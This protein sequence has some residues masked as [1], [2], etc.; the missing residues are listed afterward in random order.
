MRGVKLQY[1]EGLALGGAQHTT[2]ALP[3]CWHTRLARGISHDL[4]YKF[5]RLCLAFQWWRCQF[6][7][8]LRVCTAK[9]KRCA[10]PW[11]ISAV[12]TI[13]PIYLLVAFKNMS[14]LPRASLIT[15][16]MFH[17]SSP[18]LYE[19][20]NKSTCRP[21]GQLCWSTPGPLAKLSFTTDTRKLQN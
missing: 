21:I 8:N 7:L 5:S 10:Q 17:R 18:Q 13:Q 20:F 14:S 19:Q 6:L 4:L 2:A 9:V 16:N 15:S 11:Q 3:L 12:S 1:N